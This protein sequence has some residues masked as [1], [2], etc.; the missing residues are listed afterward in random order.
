MDSLIN[1]M[2]S[3]RPSVDVSSKLLGRGAF[4]EVYLCRVPSAKDKEALQSPHFQFQLEALKVMS[5]ANIRQ[6]KLE[7]QICLEAQ[8]LQSL[9]PNPFVVQPRWKWQCDK[10]LYFATDLCPGGE[11]YSLLCKRLDK[12]PQ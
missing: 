4:G 7:G 5:K 1:S 3:P 11:L 8:L 2:A 10:Y 6:S 12:S 9:K